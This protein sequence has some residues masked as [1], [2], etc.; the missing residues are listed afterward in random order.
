M[1]D[2]PIRAGLGALERA[3]VRLRRRRHV[4]A[5]DPA[6]HLSP[7][8]FRAIVSERLRSLQRQLDEVKGRV[9]GLIFLLVGAV[10]AQI[11][12]GLIG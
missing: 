3:L 11:L 10:A 4:D 1:S 7:E 2:A 6:P 12:L 5:G 8:A 9:N